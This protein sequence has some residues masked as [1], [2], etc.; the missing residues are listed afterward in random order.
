LALNLRQAFAQASGEAT[1]LQAPPTAREKFIADWR[2]QPTHDFSD[3]AGWR[4]GPADA[5]VQVVVWGDY[6]QSQSRNFDEHLA[7]LTSGA[8]DVSYVFL[9]YPLEKACREADTFAV[10]SCLAPSAAVAAGQLG[11]A[12]AF[13]SAHDWLMEHEG[14]LDGGQLTRIAL[15][16]GLDPA[17]LAEA[18][19]TD[20]V[21]DAIAADVDR[22]GDVELGVLPGIFINGRWVPRWRSQ[23]HLDIPILQLILDE[24]RQSP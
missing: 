20:T 1:V 2:D 5:P 10:D 7:S 12:D 23:Y 21:A 3:V 9:Q 15:D 13:W 6:S 14:P 24:A 11:G 16:A 17:A 8:T 18:V 4:R 19:G 22:A